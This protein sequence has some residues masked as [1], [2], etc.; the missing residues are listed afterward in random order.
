M[1]PSIVKSQTLAN[2][3]KSF[4]F[5]LNMIVNNTPGQSNQ[6]LGYLSPAEFYAPYQINLTV[7]IQNRVS[8]WF[9]LSHIHGDHLRASRKP[10]NVWRAQEPEVST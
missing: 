6:T 7:K 3:K 9:G 1:L 2:L 8:S 4:R 10:S 5:D